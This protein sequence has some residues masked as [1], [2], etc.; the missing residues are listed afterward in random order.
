[1][2][3]PQE[4]PAGEVDPTLQLAQVRV[5]LEHASLVF[6][7]PDAIGRMPIVVLPR[8]NLR[9]R[10]DFLLIA[11]ALVLAGILTIVFGWSFWLTA[12]AF[13]GAAVMTVLGTMSAFFVRVPEG[14]TALLTRSG[15]H[16]GVLGAG[17]HVV[18]PYL[19]VSHIVT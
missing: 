2:V 3:D 10:F 11:G 15:R 16:V 9:L 8:R 6:D 19:V 5:P 17:S 7:S 13:L 4:F 1:M 12:A 18:M 14:T